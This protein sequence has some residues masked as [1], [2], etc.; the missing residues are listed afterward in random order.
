[1]IGYVL[2]VGTFLLRVLIINSRARAGGGLGSK[3]DNTIV[4]SRGSPENG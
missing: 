3:G 4:L 2:A 1:M